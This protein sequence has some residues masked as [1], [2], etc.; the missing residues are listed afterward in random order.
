MGLTE[1]EPQEATSGIDIGAG[2]MMAGEI[3]SKITRLIEVRQ[4]RLV[5]I[6]GFWKEPEYPANPSPSENSLWKTTGL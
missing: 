2:S 5:Y 3:L 6:I 1:G 4:M